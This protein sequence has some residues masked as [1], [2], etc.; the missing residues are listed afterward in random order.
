[1]GTSAN[2]FV[3]RFIFIQQAAI[4]IEDSTESIPTL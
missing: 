2:N 4:A 3:K 1:V